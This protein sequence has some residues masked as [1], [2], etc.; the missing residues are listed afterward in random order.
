MLEKIKNKFLGT[1]LSRKIKVD[2]DDFYY[3]NP[4][5]IP[6][7]KEF[8]KNYMFS[9]LPVD[10]YEPVPDLRNT[11]LKDLSQSEKLLDMN[12]KHDFSFIEKNLNKILN[13]KIIPDWLQENP[14]FP[15]LD[16]AAYASMIENYKP[17]KII[18]VGAGYSTCLS[19]LFTEFI[20][21]KTSITAIEPFPKAHLLKL[22]E[23]NKI[24]L[25]QKKIQDID[26]SELSLIR[27][28]KENDILFIDT[29]HITVM[30][31][32]TNYIFIKLLPLLQKGVIVQIH[33]IYLPFDYSKSV[34]YER[35]TFYNEQYILASIL[36]N[37]NS[38][39][40]LYSSYLIY[41]EK[42]NSGKRNS[43]DWLKPDKMRSGGSFWMQKN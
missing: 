25:I 29:T 34:Y 1:P 36:A 19:A 42:F 8:Q 4:D 41:L 27:E 26:P 14:M 32:D 20:N 12:L 3:D 24:E 15:V 35:G 38:Y 16:L 28:L 5:R 21:L 43:D 33:D 40:P 6:N 37:S 7:L 2:L 39:T 11:D 13:E 18:E 22:K 9:L 10:F 31:S 30:D 17:Q 23:E